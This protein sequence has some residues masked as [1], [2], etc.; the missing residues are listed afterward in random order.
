MANPK[1]RVSETGGLGDDSDPVVRRM[2]Q[3]GSA[4]LSGVS[5][6]AREKNA[7]KGLDLQIDDV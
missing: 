5:P 3:L 1:K 4:R 2:R 7:S 6:H